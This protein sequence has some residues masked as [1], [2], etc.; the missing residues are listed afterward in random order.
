MHSPYP[1]GRDTPIALAMN[2]DNPEI[3][4]LSFMKRRNGKRAEDSASFEAEAS[5]GGRG[6][7]ANRRNK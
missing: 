2:R 4:K 1:V 6:P 7:E 3:I 5:N